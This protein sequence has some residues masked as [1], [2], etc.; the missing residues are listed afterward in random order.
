MKGS[1]SSHDTQE[2]LRSA[3]KEEVK[4]A[5]VDGE[6]VIQYGY[7]LLTG[8]VDN[9]WESTKEDVWKLVRA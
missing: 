6:P 7:A 1:H 3:A 2:F 9:F 4:Y 8:D 5:I